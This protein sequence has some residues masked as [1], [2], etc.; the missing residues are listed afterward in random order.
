MVKKDRYIKVDMLTSGWIKTVLLI[1]FMMI[2]GVGAIAQSLSTYNWYFGSTLNSIK[3]NR[4]NS[5]AAAVT[6]KQTPF[7]T[8]GS[9]VAT[10][11]T[12]GNLLF[13]TDGNFVYDACHA[14]MPQGFGLTGKTLA[15]Q[16]AV[17]CV[18]PGQVNKYFIFTNSASYTTG[19]AISVS[20]VDMNLFG[21]S[22]FP[23]PSL[24]DIES[25]NTLT[26]LTGRSEGMTIL[27]HGN[28]IDFW[29]ISHKNGSADYSA[30]LIN[31]TSYTGTFVTTSTT[32]IG[33]P[34]GIPISVAN[35]SVSPLVDPLKPTI[36]KMAVA[37]QTGNDDAVIVNFDNTTGVFK[38]DSYIFNTGKIA[39]GQQE[40]YDIEWDKKGQYLYISYVG[41][42]GIKADVL[43]YDYL[44][45]TNTLISVLPA[46]LNPAQS[47]GLQVGPDNLMYYLYKSSTGQFLVGNLA[48]TDTIGTSVKFTPQSF[49]AVDFGG[50]QFPSFAQ[51]TS[52]L[53]VSFKSIGT[54]QNNTTTFFPDVLPAADSLQW[55]FGD[56]V[57]ASSWS[58]VHTYA[59]AGTFSVTLTAYLQGKKMPVTLPVTITAFPLTITLVQDTTACR[60][61]FP[62]KRGKSMPV[63]FSVSA[64]IKGGTPK[65]ADWSNGQSGFTPGAS[66][67]FK[68]TLK[69]DSSGFYYLTVA[70]ASGCARASG[71]NV[72]EYGL[73]DQRS[74]K[75]YFGN[76]AG[77]DFTTNKALNDSGMTA[78]EGCAIVCDRN[79]QTIFYTDG[80]S[81]YDRTNVSIDTGIGGSPGGFS[82]QSSLIF[83]VPG[84]ETLYYIF[85]T[86]ALGET[87]SKNEVRYSLFDWK[88][89]GGKGLIVQK[90]VLLFAKSTERIIANGNW[91][92]FHEYGNSTFRSYR[93]TPNGI[94]EPVFSSIGSDHSQCGADNRIGEGYMRLGPKNILAVPLTYPG[95]NFIELFHLNDST[96][97]IVKYSTDPTNNRLDLKE[98]AGQVYGI[99]FASSNKKGVKLFATVNNGASSKFVE[100]SIDSLNKV[101][102][103]LPK[104]ASPGGE[105]G[106]LQTAPNGVIYV[107][108]KGGTGLAQVV[109]GSDL[110]IKSNIVLNALPLAPGTTSLLGLPNFRQQQGNGFGGPSMSYTGVCVG[111]STKFTGQGTDSIDKYL[112]TFGDGSSSTNA[113]QAHLY[114]KAGTYNV[115]FRVYN[116]CSLDTTLTA[117]VTI[118]D[119]PAKP[120]LNPKGEV[121]CKGPVTLDA[122]TPNTAGLTYIWSTGATSK[123]IVVNKDLAVSVTNTDVNG[124]FSKAKTLVIDNRPQLDLGPDQ[125][126]CQNNAVNVLDA[127]NPGATYVWT[128]NGVK[129]STIQ[130]QAVDT[131]LPGLTTY[132]VTITDPITTCVLTDQVV[133]TVN[134]SPLFALSVVTPPSCNTA[135]GS[136]ALTLSATAPTGGPYSYFITGP[137]FNAQAI[138]K[139]VG[140]YPLTNTAGAGTYSAIVTDQ[141]SGCTVS[142]TL[143]VSDAAWTI[144]STSS[145]CDPAS[146]TVT[147]NTS[148]GAPTFPIVYT[149]T[150]TGKGSPIVS[151]PISTN[152]AVILLPLI[153][154]GTWTVQAQDNN[155]T[156][157]IAADP[158]PLVINPNPTITITPDD[159]CNPKNVTASIASGTYT[160][161]WTFTSAAGEPVQSLGLLVSESTIKGAGDYTVSV[162]AI[163]V[164]P[165]C[166]FSKTYTLT[167]TTV[168]PTISKSNECSDQVI[169]TASPA[170][171]YTYSW[172][173][174]GA[175]QPSLLGQQ[176]ALFVGDDGSYTASLKDTKT[177]CTYT[178]SPALSV[179]IVGAITAT[180]ASTPPCK[181]GKDFTL[182][183]T[184]NST[185]AINYAWSFN[186]TTPISL[187]T[188]SIKDNRE[189]TYQVVVSSAAVPA[190]FVTTSINITRGPLPVG[191]LPSGSIICND[192][193]NKD[194]LTAK[195]DLNPGVFVQYNWYKNDVLLS[196][197]KQ[198]LTANSAGIYKVDLT[199]S[200]NCIA[201]DQTDVRNE[202]FPKLTAPNA[203]RPGSKSGDN[204]SFYVY[205]FFITDQFEVVIFNRWGEIVFESKD[206]YFKWNGT[207]NNTGGLL[208]GGTYAYVLKYT[209]S[210]RPDKGIQEQHGGVVLVR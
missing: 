104:I 97:R 194:P 187:T 42:A 31:S 130:Q 189:G 26:G 49:G 141:I 147:I 103:L 151:A 101:Q 92:I 197:T 58:P 126:V 74:N 83:Q 17:I 110:A 171:S 163:G 52:T 87:G 161:Q 35:F 173:K 204:Q 160:Y 116:R 13:Y 195:V 56:K 184:A 89:N 54:C 202:C 84:D 81:V 176:V 149:F 196:Y 8:G 19:G 118:F 105:L 191:D 201:S 198:T 82:S 15:N 162:T 166:T 47:L 121:L 157:C 39:V 90:N 113:S 155:G 174:G 50:T 170:G 167:T 76:K 23:S 85:T 164:A 182:T 150:G 112:W 186:K 181:D 165:A 69:P 203:F 73:N 68:A 125:T 75:W 169:L 27:P 115:S 7:G 80:N 30:T 177:G 152:P 91:V 108:V 77:I 64:T 4:G 60:D 178:S 29:L 135:N 37:P 99:E 183:T 45:P 143:G 12:N 38:F 22:A 2:G 168:V 34:S 11:P 131:T 32:S 36:R 132:A 175:A 136:I 1:S 208:P 61:E 46:S 146:V 88:L 16:P 107:A 120:S 190:C 140:N 18:V 53:V 62:P 63:Q 145:L 55:D 117:K 41:D 24:G 129:T 111:D 205:S 192:P 44:N 48:K 148:L 3:F 210:F 95:A 14:Q 86:Q 28:G 70:D 159:V 6:N 128:V 71:V 79:G 144:S 153:P 66:G 193:D 40:I 100:F 156:G 137:A 199:N 25:K 158:T 123:T 78:P 98:A 57:G 67:T 106:A 96:G 185:S 139:T 180:L 172:Q 142:S 51:S 65:S 134:V 179:N 188:P 102:L 5:K 33:A 72:K 133:V 20:V 207:Y 43:Q 127:L 93:I 138:D 206:R 122:N 119:P 59:K 209:S 109:P 114:A 124:C 200:Y 10:D 21:T 94:G 154:Q 9:A